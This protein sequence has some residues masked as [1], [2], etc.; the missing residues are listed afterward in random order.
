M[1]AISTLL[2]HP[3]VSP[4]VAAVASTHSFDGRVWPVSW[5]AEATSVAATSI[6]ERKGSLSMGRCYR[7]SAHT[8]GRKRTGTRRRAFSE[9]TKGTK[10]DTYLLSPLCD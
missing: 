4:M 2:V 6:D 10:E 8:E 7:V 3:P 9:V 1:S 5:M